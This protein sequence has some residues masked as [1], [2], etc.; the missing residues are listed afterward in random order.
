MADLERR[1]RYALVQQI[2][3]YI[4]SKTAMSTAEAPERIDRVL[5][6]R[7]TSWDSDDAFEY[8][9]RSGDTFQGLADLHYGDPKLWW[10]IADHNYGTVP[11]VFNI[12]DHT[13]ILIPRQ[14]V[15]GFVPSQV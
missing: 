14:R 9:T 3:R 1:S 6:T 12:P 7:Y 15:V 5:S 4:W 10:I 13:V 8:V 2:G 11:D